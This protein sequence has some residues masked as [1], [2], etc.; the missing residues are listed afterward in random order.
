MQIENPATLA[1]G[2]DAV[3]RLENAKN[4][5]QALE[6]IAETEVR[7]VA[8]AFEGW[9][10]H[11]CNFGIGGRN[12]G[13]RRK[14]ECQLRLAKGANPGRC[15]QSFHWRSSAG[16]S[17][18]PRNGDPGSGTA[19]STFAD[20]P[21][22]ESH[23]AADWRAA[24]AYQYRSCPPRG[25]SADFH[26]LAQELADFSKSVSEDTQALDIHTM[27]AGRNRKTKQLLSVELPELKEKL[28]SIETDLGKAL[29]EVEASLTQL[30]KTPAQFRI[31]VQ[32]IA[33]Q[34]AG[35]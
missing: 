9:P 15:R 33:Q 22:P 35:S 5:L 14:R 1:A 28:A 29:E 25:G 3:L 8:K 31:G 23:C 34:V 13:L 21:G 19:E 24:R 26:Y 7:S 18:N 27:T 32:D 10:L 2:D 17:G 11:R 20:H 12:C 6:R 4:E 30:S 16:D